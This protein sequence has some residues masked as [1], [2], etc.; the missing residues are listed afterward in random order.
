MPMIVDPSAPPVTMPTPA[1]SADGWL[2][3]TLDTTYAGV[4]L[5]VDYTAGTPLADAADVRKVRI[6]RLDTGATTPV[7]VRS[8]DQAW[9]MGGVGVAYDHEAPFGAA[10]IYQAVPEYADG[11]TGPTSQVAVTLSN[12][13]APLDVWIKSLDEP[14]AS[15]LVTVTA[16]PQMQWADRIDRADVQ[17]SRYPATGQDVYSS[18][19]GDISIDAEGDAIETMRTLLTTPGVRLIQTRSD[20][21]RP[22]MYVLFSQPAESIDATPTGARTFTAGVTQV[23]RPDTAGQPLRMPNWSYD[24]VADGYATYDAVEAAY[25]S[26]AS[27]ATNGIA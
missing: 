19:T 10:V 21:H 22:D 6:S 5:D 18:A 7:P 25:S 12:P 26:Y 23:E 11:T 15:A 2:T 17:G 16:W 20:Y 13:E 1:V 9:A 14:G 24:A 4:V 27:L 3:A 8:A